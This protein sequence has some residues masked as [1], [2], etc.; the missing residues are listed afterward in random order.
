LQLEIRS[1]GSH[2]QRLICGVQER[3]GQQQECHAK[4]KIQDRPCEI[5]SRIV[6]AL[7]LLKIRF[8]RR[9]RVFLDYKIPRIYNFG[10]DLIP[11]AG[12]PI[13]NSIRQNHDLELRE[14]SPTCVQRPDWSHTVWLFR[15][16]SDFS[17]V[18]QEL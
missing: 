4:E 17:E 11:R 3:V 9:W 6:H 1:G 14:E 7:I 2:R 5:T 18:R 8:A 13:C 16:I 12:G 10:R 15:Q